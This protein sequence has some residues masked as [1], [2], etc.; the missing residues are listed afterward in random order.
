MPTAPPTNVEE[1]EGEFPAGNSEFPAGN[2]PA[3]PVRKSHFYHETITNLVRN[4][5]EFAGH[6]MRGKTTRLLNSMLRG[7]ALKLAAMTQAGMVASAQKMIN[8]G[9]FEMM[10]ATA[11]DGCGELREHCLDFIREALRAYAA[12]M[13][14]QKDRKEELHDAAAAAG[15][16]AGKQKPQRMQTKAGLTL[17]ISVG[18]PF[19]DAMTNLRINKAYRVAVTAVLEF[20]LRE[21]LT[22]AVRIC[23]DR[24]P[25][26]VQISPWHLRLALDQ[27]SD[28][29][30]AFDAFR[31]TFAIGGATPYV[32]PRI[33]PNRDRTSQRRRKKAAAEGG[34]RPHRFHPGTVALRFIRHL[35]NGS[36]LQISQQGM[37]GLVYQIVDKELLPELGPFMRNRRDGEHFAGR[38]RY[39]ASFHHDLQ[40]LVEQEVICLLREALRLLLDSGRKTMTRD[41]VVHIARTHKYNI[42]RDVDL[43]MQRSAGDE[44]DP[45]AAV[46]DDEDDAEEIARLEASEQEPSDEEQDH[47]AEET[48]NGA[49]EAEEAEE[50]EEPAPEHTTELG[51]Q[52][53]P[54]VQSKYR[55][56][57]RDTT[58]KRFLQGAG[59][60]RNGAGAIAAAGALTRAVLRRYL[61]D[62]LNGLSNRKAS[63]MTIGDVAAGAF[64]LRSQVIAF[65]SERTHVL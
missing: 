34:P 43:C 44:V 7:L 8:P 45:E 56:A 37:R 32:D 59:S 10:V 21:L 61:R 58:C 25:A 46:S 27:H 35:Q 3:A 48:P 52:R 15:E 38:V 13:Q 65:P 54:I 9:D 2:S 63:T 19:I 14:V 47:P 5:E 42:G 36:Q 28:L 64:L 12:S 18:T 26:R 31:V 30:A 40:C 23:K 4:H 55:D 11:L 50:A 49:G 20:L 1:E 22:S 6:Q 60:K 41:V 62:G 16:P 17:G 33:L 51:N 29:A 39:E 53:F 57:V 24:R